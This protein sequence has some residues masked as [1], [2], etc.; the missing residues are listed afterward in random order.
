ME[1]RK[2]GLLSP[3]G[4]FTSIID[5]IDFSRCMRDNQ[6]VFYLCSSED[7]ESSYYSWVNFLDGEVM[8]SIITR[9]LK[10]LIHVQETEKT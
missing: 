1:L 4:S 9:T 3:L 10:S 7:E 5:A 8:L 6:G 2:D